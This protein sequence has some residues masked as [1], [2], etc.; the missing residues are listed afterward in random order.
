MGDADLSEVRILT[1]ISF[2]AASSYY[3]PFTTASLVDSVVNSWNSQIVT[4]KG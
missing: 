1:S 3:K 4:N 2:S